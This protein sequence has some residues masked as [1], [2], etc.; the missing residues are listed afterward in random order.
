MQIIYLISGIIA[1]AGIPLLMLKAAI[2]YSDK[3]NKDGE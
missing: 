1:A 3:Q 2:Y